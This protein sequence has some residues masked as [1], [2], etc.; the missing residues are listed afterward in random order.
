MRKLEKRVHTPY[1][2]ASLKLPYHASHWSTLI[3][4]SDLPRPGGREDFTFQRK[5]EWVLGS[6]LGLHWFPFNK[7]TEHF[8]MIK[9]PHSVYH[10]SKVSGQTPIFGVVFF[11]SKSLSGIEKQSFK[12]LQF[13]PENLGAMLEYWYIKRGL[14]TRRFMLQTK[15]ATKKQFV[16]F[17]FS[18]TADQFL[19]GFVLCS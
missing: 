1:F 12:K 19:N 8:I 15:K 13:W 11:V 9:R 16:M 5:T 14:S 6:R 2:S 4:N 17:V 3:S 18:C 10:D 7:Y